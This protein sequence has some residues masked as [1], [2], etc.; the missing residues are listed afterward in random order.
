MLGPAFVSE[1]IPDYHE[2]LLILK[3]RS[4]PDAVAPEGAAAAGFSSPE[5]TEALSGSPGLST[6]S[7]F[8][9]AGLIKQVVPL[10]RPAEQRTSLGP[11]GAMGILAASV[12]VPPPEDRNAGVNIVQVENDD[13]VP[14][15][16]MA[17]GNDP[18]VEFASRVPVRYLTADSPGAGIEAVPPPASTMWNLQKIQ[19]E[20]TR[21]LPNFREADDI[22]VAV[23]DTG[24]DPNHPDLDQRVSSY[25][26]EHPDVPSASSDQDIIGHGTHVAGTITA[27]SNN[28]L[29]INGICNCQ[30]RV[31][32]IFD[33]RPDCV[34]GAP[35][36]VPPR[37]TYFVNPV[38]YQRALADC[39]D[40]GV[41][42]V[43]LSIGGRG[44]PD[45]NELQLFNE[46][47]NSG[48]TV[49]AAM[50]N[51]RRGGSPTSF[52]AAIPGVIAVGAT[53]L[54]DT[55]ANFS[56]RGN[57]ISLC[58]PG[59]AIWS[60]LPTHPGQS[61][62]DATP[63]LFGRCI[64]GKPQRRETDYDAWDGTSMASP[65][66]AA[67]VALLLANQGKM[68]PADV[69]NRLMVTVDK[70]PAMQGA[71]FHSDYGAGRLNLLR[72]LSP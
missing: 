20:A 56:N 49:V 30:L 7:V 42:V 24:I 48:T 16:Q 55:V 60:T 27:N 70:V 10:S 36:L 12:E 57:H 39:L 38:M 40:E 9:R 23:L 61:G 45:Q 69:R 17:L 58:A 19:W 22:Q 2:G 31:W 34:Q 44:Q 18:N 35:P 50:G 41:D 13:S 15:L 66:V 25:V 68:N 51:E 8:E 3:V 1:Q 64:Q 72:L 14:D 32:K 47:L 21:E 29:G 62:F 65:H 33:D 28:E 52:P 6:L 5:V 63:G 67:A 53:R 71:D 43:N 54:D 4:L 11:M 37:F 59:V 26:F 46:L